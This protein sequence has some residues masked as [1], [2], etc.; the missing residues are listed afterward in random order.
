MLL[1]DTMSCS[2][3]FFDEALISVALMLQINQKKSKYSVKQTRNDRSAARLQAAVHDRGAEESA[4]D[5]IMIMGDVPAPFQT[6]S[7]SQSGTAD[8]RPLDGGYDGPAS[9]D[10]SSAS[11]SGSQGAESDLPSER[12]STTDVSNS[13]TSSFRPPPSSSSSTS[14]RHPTVPMRA[15]RQ[16]LQRIVSGSSC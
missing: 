11:S 15:A 16:P 3:K 13:L 12:T 6:S 1:I 8:G 9:S 10:V 2:E 4:D 5:V 7:S 14:G